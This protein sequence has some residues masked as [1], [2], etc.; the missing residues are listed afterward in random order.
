[1]AGYD[2]VGKKVGAGGNIL[3]GAVGGFAVAELELG[4]LSELASGSSGK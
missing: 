4:Q 3:G 2:D 1:M